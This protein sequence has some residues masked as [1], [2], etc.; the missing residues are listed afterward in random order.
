MKIN[1]VRSSWQYT[2]RGIPQ[3]SQ[4]DPCIFDIFLNNMFYFIEALRQT[5]NY[6]DDNS[7]AKIDSDIT[8]IKAELEIASGVAVQWFNENFMKAN[9]SKFQTLCVSKA[10]NPPVLELLIDGIIVRS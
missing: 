3:G 6:A 7:L 1:D 10:V 2:I 9:A 5:I 8:V 4:A